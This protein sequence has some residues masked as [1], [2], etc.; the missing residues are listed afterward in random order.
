MT[1][2]FGINSAIFSLKSYLAAMMATY[3]AFSIGLERPYWAFLTSY[4]VA[5]PLA[6]AV[7][8]KAFFRVI[9]TFVGASAAVF[10]VPPLA[11]SPELLTLAIAFWLALCVFVS[12]LDRTPRG[13]TFVPESV[14]PLNV[15]RVGGFSSRKSAHSSI[16]VRWS[17]RLSTAIVS[18]G[19]QPV[20]TRRTRLATASIPASSAAA[21]RSN[22]APA[23]VSLACLALRSNNRTSSASSI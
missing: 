13:Y 5:G 15:S 22:S 21:S 18:W 8:S 19:S 9:G 14:S 12:L 6:G 20:A 7:V 16:S 3:I 4:I 17:I 2:R 1:T 23:G 11:H 10:M